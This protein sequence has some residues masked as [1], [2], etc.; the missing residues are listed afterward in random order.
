VP[1]GRLNWTLYPVRNLGVIAGVGGLYAAG[2]AQGL[3]SGKS[4]GEEL[5][6]YVIPG[7][8]SLSYRFDFLNEQVFVPSLQA[9]GDYWAFIEDN[10]FQDDVKGGKSGWHAGAGLGILLDRLEW[11]SAFRLESDFGIENVFLEVS[12][13]KT[14][15]NH[16]GLDFSGLVYSAGFLFEF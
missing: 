4:S 10:E 7:Q 15:M 5:K 9:G 13:Q 14:W 16:E 1:G 8:L 12:A 2:H 3:E 6:L 11:E